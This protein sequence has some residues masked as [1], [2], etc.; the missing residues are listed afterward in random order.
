MKNFYAIFR[1]FR[2]NN[3][4]ALKMTEHIEN[5]RNLSDAYRR[6]RNKVSLFCGIGLAWSAAQ[7]ELKKISLGEVGELDL[8]GASIPL[9]I[10]FCILYLFIRCI[11]EF[12]MQQ[13]E[14]RRW[15]LAGFDFKLTWNLVRGSLLML[16]ASG[17]NRSTTT[18]AYIAI[19]VIV[20]LLL[21]FLFQIVGV[22]VLTPLLIS[23]RSRQGRYSVAFSVFAAEGWGRLV[24]LILTVAALITI[25]FAILQYP[26]L[27][28]LWPTPPNPIAI[29]VATITAIVVLISFTFEEKYMEKLFALVEIDKD[30]VVTTYNEGGEKGIVFKKIKK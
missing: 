1:I 20:F 19:S 6:S 5:H 7:F 29:W 15:R 27:Y 11:I 17:L 22:F 13:K 25:A 3:C 30:G 26:P 23:I 28:K 16:A 24:L 8:S 10:A 12:A 9:L 4:L 18:V 14:V 2:D 21:S